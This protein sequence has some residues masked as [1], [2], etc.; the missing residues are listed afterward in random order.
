MNKKLFALFFVSV[1]AFSLAGCALHF[2]GWH[3]EPGEIDWETKTVPVEFTFS[4]SGSSSDD[5]TAAFPMDG[6]S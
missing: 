2:G 6:K 5:V 3:Y 1:L 4:I